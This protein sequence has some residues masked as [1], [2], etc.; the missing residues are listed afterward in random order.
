MSPQLIAKCLDCGFQAPYSPCTPACPNCGS[1]WREALYDYETLGKTLPSLLANRPFNLWR[2]RELLPV[3]NPS[4]DLSFGEG[5]TPMFRA[6]N[7]GLMLGNPNLF[8]KDE[9]QGPTHS[10]KD[11]QAAVTIAALKEAGINELVLASTGNVAISYSAYA[12]R[13]GMKL[14][15]FLT[16]LVPA[17]KMRETALYGTQVVKVTGSYDQAK[18]TAALFAKRRGLFL[19]KGARSIPCIESMKTIAFETS[20]QLTTLLGAPSTE[21]TW[22]APDWYIQSISGGMGPLG[23]I[24]GYDELMAMGLIDHFPK[25][26]LIQVDGCAPMVHAWKQGLDVAQ[27]VVAPRTLIHT[28]ATGDPG[29]TYTMLRKKIMEK[30]SGFFEMASDEEAYRA[31]HFLAKM[32]GLSVE[33]AAAVAIAGVIKMVRSGVIKHD[34]TVVINCTGHTI[35]VERNILGEGW[36]KDLTNLGGDEMEES[37]EEG[38]LAALSKVGIDR[39]PRIAIVDDNPQVR[40]LIRRILQSQGNYTL[41]EATNGREAV[42][43][44]KKE[45]PNLMILDLM[46]PEMDGFAVMDVLQA[47]KDTS[48]IPIIVITAKELTPAEK[49]RLRGHIQ[50]LMQKGDFL[51][52]DLLDEVRA[53]LG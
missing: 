53:L 11:R 15:V 50:S 34:E 7:L 22:Q 51:S 21:A 6:T 32:E 10:F 8:I 13:A 9:R 41:F 43:L 38:L 30:T 45:H 2:Y 39:F 42:D 12:A 25:I 26:G 37:K 47:D 36:A 46:M 3:N 40:Q 28:L 33:P 31:M 16:S 18:E 48:D 35:P 24:K 5:G 14:W 4:P 20:E 19:D 1:E 44:A 29:R 23:V 49:D 17:V 27:P 52:D